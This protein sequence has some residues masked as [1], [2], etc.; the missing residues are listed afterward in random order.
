MRQRCCWSADFSA[1]RSTRF[2]AQW[3]WGASLSRR[4]L[5]ESLLLALMGGAIG[6][7]L[8]FAVVELFKRIAGHAIPRLDGVTA[9][10]AV[11]AWGLGAAVLAS[12]FAGAFPALRAFR[13]EPMSV[14]K[15]AGPKGTAGIGGRRF[16]RGVTMVQTA[17]TLAL[18]VGAGLLI[19]T[20]MNIANVPSGY[21]T[22]RIYDERHRRW[23]AGRRGQLSSPGL[24][25]VA[26]LPVVQYAA[27]AGESR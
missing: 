15:D 11:L 6:V 12:V 1:S 2:A 25:R 26:A 27:F 23:T 17:L 24:E 7:G 5:T 18:L 22:E 3:A 20:M 10:W 21:N 9:G 13:L 16:L 19:R 8:V 4:V 14:L